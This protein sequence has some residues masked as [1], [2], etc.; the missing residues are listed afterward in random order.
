MKGI[1]E[2]TTREK[3]LKK[4]RASLLQ[5]T[6][7]PYPRLSFD[8]QVFHLPHTDPLVIFADRAEKAGVKFFL[9]GDELDFMEA[10]VNLS[11]QHKWRNVL[12]VEDGLS[13]LMTECEYP[14][15]ISTDDI[16]R[17]DVAVSSCEC[18]VARTGSVVLSSREN[19]RSAPA[20]APIHIVLA[21]VSQLALDL[22]DA[23]SWMKHKYNRLPSSFSIITGPSRTADIEGQPVIG[24]HGP[25][26]LYVFV[27]DDRAQ[28]S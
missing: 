11:I 22:K 4:I 6:D 3:V 2:S 10:L 25:G 28:G 17:I 21:R 13:N 19:T 23:L 18:M 7:N 9:A 5:Q 26:E 16:E 24:V 27:I 14:H 20:Y 1:D 12:C 8:Q 15:H